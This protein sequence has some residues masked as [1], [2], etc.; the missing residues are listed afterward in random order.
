MPYLITDACTGCGACVRLCPTRAIAGEKKKAHVIDKALCIECGACGRV[1]P[2]SAIKDPAA[3]LCRMVKRSQWKKPVFDADSCISCGMCI[4]ACPADCLSFMEPG[5][6][7]DIHPR[8]GLTNPKACLGCGFCADECPSG[9]IT[10]AVPSA[11]D[12]QAAK[13]AGKV[14]QAASG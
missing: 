14:S 2:N 8:P 3:R 12:E 9:S 10:M 7:K 6:K 13:P 11:E 5:G 1:C 4:D